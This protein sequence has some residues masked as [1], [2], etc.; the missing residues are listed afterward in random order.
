MLFTLR[1]HQSE[2]TALS[3]LP[4]HGGA[5]MLVSGDASGWLFLW[6]LKFRRPICSWQ[7]HPPP[8]PTSGGILHLQSFV[9]EFELTPHFGSGTKTELRSIFLASQ[10]RDN[11]VHIW[12]L[13]SILHHSAK[14]LSPMQLQSALPGPA[15][16]FSFPSNS[17]NFCRFALTHTPRTASTSTD[18]VFALPNLVDSARIDIYNYTTHAY[19]VR[20]IGCETS[21]RTNQGPTSLKTGIVMCM[22]FYHRSLGIVTVPCATADQQIPP[23]Q[24][25]LLAAG[26][27][28]G[29]V[30]IWN[31]SDGTQ[32]GKMQLH[33]EPIMS[34]DIVG[35]EYAYQKD[36]HASL[37]I[38]GSWGV[39]VA[40][41]NQLTLFSTNFDI[42]GMVAE[43]HK[44][45]L[46]STGTTDVRIQADGR[47]IATAGWDGAL[48]LFRPSKR[49]KCVSVVQVFKDTIRC[50]EYCPLSIS[51]LL[52]QLLLQPCSG[53]SPLLSIPNKGSTEEVPRAVIAVGSKDG[54]ICL[55]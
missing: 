17:L 37:P 22:R 9:A 51:T 55:L 39:S 4:D 18:I 14:H 46:P 6:D 24:T 53:A 43:H 42:N 3:F 41:D 36:A 20:S 34:I 54:R 50:M 35:S 40:A 28:S 2:L 47:A 38:A 32:L 48:R 10:G 16:I 29:H 19:G 26:Y 52:S 12:S 31:T 27:E 21:N 49:L 23:T 13:D 5:P 30:I 15:P 1:G 8:Q 44:T 25:L 33:S 45:E 7:A 11:I